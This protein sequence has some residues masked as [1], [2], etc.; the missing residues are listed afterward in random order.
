MEEF[1]KANKRKHFIVFLI[2][3]YSIFYTGWEIID[4]KIKD[5]LFDI[6]NVRNR[7]IHPTFEGEPKN[8]AIYT[9][10]KLC[11]TIDLILKIFSI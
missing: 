7:Y 10:N 9:L 2:P 6:N 3:R 1:L 4:K 5:N 11:K 8:D